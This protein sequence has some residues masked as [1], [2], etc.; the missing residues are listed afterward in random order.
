MLHV[1]LSNSGEGNEAIFKTPVTSISLSRSNVV[2]VYYSKGREVMKNWRVNS[3]M[4]EL[5]IMLSGLLK[6]TL[7]VH[8]NYNSYM[9]VWS[10]PSWY[11]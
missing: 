1:E 6:C 5:I 10:R 3:V 2:Y 9:L 11:F 4:S 8:Y 7:I